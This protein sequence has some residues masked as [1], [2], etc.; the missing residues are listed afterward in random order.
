MKYDDSEFRAWFCLLLTIH[1]LLSETCHTVHLPSF[2]N[3]I[4]SVYDKHF[5]KFTTSKH[6]YTYEWHCNGICWLQQ[7][8]PVG[9]PAPPFTQCQNSHYPLQHATLAGMNETLKTRQRR[10]V[11]NTGRPSS[12]PA[13]TWEWKHNSQSILRHCE[14]PGQFPNISV[15]VHGGSSMTIMRDGHSS[16]VIHWTDVKWE[17][18]YNLHQKWRHVGMFDQPIGSAEPVPKIH[19]ATQITW[20]QNWM[21]SSH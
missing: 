5:W 11:T 19:C 15:R 10:V 14:I 16:A 3:I 2:C 1:H 8:C 21:S 20:M 9:L 18:N 12:L 6:R 13:C 17:Q 4:W 7:A